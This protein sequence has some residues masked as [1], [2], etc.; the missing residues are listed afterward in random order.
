MTNH[1]EILE[2]VAPPVRKGG[3]VVETVDDLLNKL[4]N[5]AK[6]L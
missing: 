3:V 5:E 4:R 6:V 2:T 1:L